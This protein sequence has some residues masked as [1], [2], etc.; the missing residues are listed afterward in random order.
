M[1]VACERSADVVGSSLSGE[2]LEL[3]AAIS[4]A[5]GFS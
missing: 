2:A 4:V 3:S 5:E 1:R